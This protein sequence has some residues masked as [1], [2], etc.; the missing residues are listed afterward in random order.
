MKKKGGVEN[1]IVSQARACTCFVF[2]N[3]QPLRTTFGI[4]IVATR[5]FRRT[6]KSRLALTHLPY[7][8]AS[9]VVVDAGDCF[10][11]RRAER[12]ASVFFRAITVVSLWRSLARRDLYVITAKRWKLFW[13]EIEQPRPARNIILLSMTH[14]L[15]RKPRLQPRICIKINGLPGWTNNSTSVRSQNIFFHAYSRC[16]L[17]IKVMA[18]IFYMPSCTSIQ[19]Y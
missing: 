12:I 18:R 11:R 15:L 10:D 19:N 8:L 4:L 3:L 17:I 1:W 2:I 13:G 6:I 16:V 9:S 14:V 5:S 7:I